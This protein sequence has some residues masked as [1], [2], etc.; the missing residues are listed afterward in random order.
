MMSNISINFSENILSINDKE[1]E[2]EFC[3]K[4]FIEFKESIV[5]L[6][7]IPSNIKYNNNI[8]CIDKL[9]NVIWQVGNV[10]DVT[11][12]ENQPYTYIDISDEKN[13]IVAGDSLGVDYFINIETGI[14]EYSGVSK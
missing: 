12:G 2:F 8:F 5:V 6:L 3:I 10:Y 11:K 1:I 13:C 4:E 7:E 14:P 9:C